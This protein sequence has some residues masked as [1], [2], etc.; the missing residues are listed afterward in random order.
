MMYLIESL[1]LDSGSG[2]G[3][4]LAHHSI[5][6]PESATVGLHGLSTCVTPRST[7]HQRKRQDQVVESSQPAGLGG[8]P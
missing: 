1:Y 5:P 6:T 3:P 2:W 8:P 4:T 7:S